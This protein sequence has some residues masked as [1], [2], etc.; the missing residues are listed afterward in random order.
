MLKG[1]KPPVESSN[2]EPDQNL[3]G[4]PTFMKF[5]DAPPTG[6]VGFDPLDEL[7]MRLKNIKDGL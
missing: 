4:Y 2:K 5:T 1:G 7:D 3:G 6:K